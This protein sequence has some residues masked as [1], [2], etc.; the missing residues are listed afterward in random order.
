M[1]DQNQ[2]QRPVEGA[3]RGL[4]K[5]L[6]AVQYYPPTHP[7]LKGA[8]AE[9]LQDFAT[10]LA[11]GQN[12]VVAVRKDG[13]SVDDK[14]VG[15]QNPILAKLAPF[16]FARRIQS[17]LFLPD[18]SG[19]DLRTFA[20]CLTLEP[21]ELVRLGGI[22]EVML[23]ARIA[24]IWANQLDLAK[25]L[26]QKE[27]IEEQKRAVGEEDPDPLEEL[28]GMGPDREGNAGEERTL[29]RIIE[30]LRREKVDQHYR[31]LVQELVPAIHLNLKEESRPLVLEA[32]SLLAANAGNT[33]L[34]NA[35]REHSVHALNQLT[36]D[37]VLDYLVEILCHPA[38]EEEERE[39]EETLRETV[40]DILLSLQGK[41]VVRRLM[42]HLA[43]ESNARVR[44]ILSDTLIRQGK[45]AVPILLDY[46]GEEP[47]FVV[48]NAVAILGE[49]RD[50]EAASSL[51]PLLR[52]KDVR[53]R[54][55]TIR[56]LTKI[57]GRSAVGILLRTL[58]E[59]DQELRR[60]ALLSLGAMKD[61]AAVPALVRLVEDPDPMFKRTEVKKEAIKA[62]GEIGSAD[63]VPMLVDLLGHRTFWRRAMQNEL[64]TAA[65]Q[66]LGEIGHGGSAPHLEK[67]VDD[68][69]PEVSRAAA[70]ALKQ[71]RRGEEH[72][73]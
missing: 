26:A 17:L 6:K 18:L 53:V 1:S 37:S 57:G 29:A 33:R 4:V 21:N 72:G 3:L 71:M 7:T 51:T 16:L 68:R 73:P 60:Q 8:V 39:H 63:A 48:R 22:K 55:E 58:E 28:E 38:T 64:R 9:S 46:L 20:R 49:I 23:R 50:Q 19:E 52:H 40:M 54:R 24:T 5:L 43:Q 44:K 34:S 31:Y 11:N 25:I 67:A 13:F 69:S 30:E 36:N 10:L 65:A 27:E 32:L 59:G 12:L 56:A 45:N 62:L 61:P 15:G 14:V 70:Q 35:R 42:D 2:Q 66:A 47:W 41:A